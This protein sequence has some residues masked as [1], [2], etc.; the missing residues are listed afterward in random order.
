[1]TDLRFCLLW[2]KV[3]SLQSENV[4]VT[5]K[6]ISNVKIHPM[7]EKNSSNNKKY[8]MYVK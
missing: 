6:A 3:I 1:M 5:M 7:I 2:S 4:K 8:D